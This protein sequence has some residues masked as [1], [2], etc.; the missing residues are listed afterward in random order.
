MRYMRWLFFVLLA[1][2]FLMSY[3][4]VSV[5]AAERVSEKESVALT[6]YNQDFAVVKEVRKVRLTSGVNAIE[7][8]DVAARI[9]PTSVHL[10]SLTYPGSV[11]IL[12]QNYEFDLLNYG[13]LLNKYVGKEIEINTVV[14]TKTNKKK[15]VKARLLSSGYM[16]Q[17]V[18][19]GQN[20]GYQFVSS[21]QPLFEIDGKIHT[22]PGGTIV[23]PS[24]PGGLILKPTLSWQLASRNGGVH[25][26]EL[27]YMTSGVKWIADYVAILNEDDT[28]LDLTG[29]VTLDNRS[30]ATYENAKL[31][32]VAGDVNKQKPEEEGRGLMMRKAMMAEDSSSGPQFKEKSF[33][34]YHLYTL[35]RPTTLKEQ[36][37]KQVEFTTSTEVPILKRY[38]YDGFALSQQYRHQNITYNRTQPDYMASSKK[39]VWVAIE[40]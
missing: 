16:S 1:V 20:R 18:G 11:T 27:A 22:S 31:K 21:G 5:A 6:V 33:F 28:K 40:F 35:Q 2:Q 37:I 30:G 19:Y 36:E 32:L 15:L 24:L 25:T 39:D 10:K 14:D 17:S 23:L 3:P 7:L 34:E 4:A 9:D 26:V 12:E 29:W 13:K 38:I 8:E